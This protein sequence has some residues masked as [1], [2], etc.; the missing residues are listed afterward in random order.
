MVNLK[1]TS[2]DLEELKQM[3]LKLDTSKDGQLSLEEISNG[4]EQ[5]FGSLKSNAK[6]YKDIMKSLD[7]DGNGY[8]DY[9]EYITAAIDKAAMLSKDNLKA[10]FELLDTDNSGVITIDELKGAFD[11]HGDHD[12]GLW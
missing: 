1:A 3:F 8:I 2:E 4:L 6:E 5:V 12:E 11:T 10:A 9:N 7:R